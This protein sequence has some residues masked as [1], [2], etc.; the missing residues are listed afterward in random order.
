LSAAVMLE[1][2]VTTVIRPLWWLSGASHLR[3]MTLLPCGGRRSWERNYLAFW[4]APGRLLPDLG[5]RERSGAQAASGTLPGVVDGCDL[6]RTGSMEEGNGG[7]LVVPNLGPA[8]DI[9]DD[10]GRGRGFLKGETEVVAGDG[11]G[12]AVAAEVGRDLV[13]AQGDLGTDDAPIGGHTPM[14]THSIC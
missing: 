1:D 10:D 14:F 11:F 12:R 5:L 4:L 7:R 9:A 13:V 3:A 6:G 2:Q 8:V